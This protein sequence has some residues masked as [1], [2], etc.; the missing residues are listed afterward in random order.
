M[1]NQIALRVM[2]HP[3]DE[4]VVGGEAHMLWHETGAASAL[5]GVQI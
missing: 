2:A 3:G 5:A 1:A 4:V